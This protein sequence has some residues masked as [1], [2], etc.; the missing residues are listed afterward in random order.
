MFFFVCIFAFLINLNYIS[1][2]ENF[3]LCVFF[4]LFFIIVYSV[5][6]KSFKE[7]IFI[8]IF[9]NFFIILLILKLNIYFNKV[10]ML[11]YIIKRN[12]INKYI[13]KILLIK[14]KNIIKLNNI[15]NYY[16]IILNFIFYL[17]LNKNIKLKEIYI[18]LNFFNFVKSLKKNDFALFF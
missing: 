17:N 14:K 4:V 13:S 5:I 8:K 16:L 12:I 7:F 2:N 6:K 10:L 11:Y 1:Y 18:N 15:F 3:L 9:K